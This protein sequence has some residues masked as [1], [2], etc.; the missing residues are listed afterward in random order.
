MH[1]LFLSLLLPTA[2]AAD[3]DNDGC[4]DSFF[5][6]N[7]ACVATTASL[8]ASVVVEASSV[9]RD[10]ASIGA[11]TTIESGVHIGEGTTITGRISASG[12]RR[13]QTDTYIGRR[14]TLGADHLIGADN[15]IGRS[16]DIGA[17]IETGGAVALGYGG[18][19]GDDVSIGAGT[20][21]G[22]LVQIG[23]NTALAAGTVLGRGVTILDSA[24]STS[25]G[26]IIGP[27]VHIGTNASISTTARIRKRTTLGDDVTVMG[28]VRIGRDAQIGDGATVGANVRIAAGAQVTANSDVPDGAVISR[29]VEFDN[30]ASSA[31]T[32]AGCLTAT[33][34]PN[35]S[36]QDVLD[37]PVGAFACFISNDGWVYALK[38]SNPLPRTTGVAS[39]IGG[40][41]RSYID[42]VWTYNPAGAGT[43]R[44]T[45]TSDHPQGTAGGG[46]QMYTDGSWYGN[47]AYWLFSDANCTSNISSL[48]YTYQIWSGQNCGDGLTT[49][50]WAGDRKSVV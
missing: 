41:S 15:S 3:S 46:D 13:I 7:G 30:A 43:W 8:A 37:I 32:A 39:L 19:V 48:S 49:L 21:V 9:I 22:N 20:V 1:L 23:D 50:F 31:T 33:I 29:G 36:T 11:D 17:R 27:D 24:S 34:H 35:N 28:S 44:Q 45:T 47:G 4:V 2:S 5:D 42:E 40:S 14:V 16:V 38:L 10:H 6:A 25:I 12:P 18:V 26:G